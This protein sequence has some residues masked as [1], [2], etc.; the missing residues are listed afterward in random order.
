M[1]YLEHASEYPVIVLAHKLADYHLVDFES[2]TDYDVVKLCR[3]LLF[4]RSS[5]VDYFSR[6]DA[7]SLAAKE[8][9]NE[10]P[11][12]DGTLS[13]QF[14]RDGLRPR[15]QLVDEQ[16]VCS[17]DRVLNGDGKAPLVFVVVGDGEGVVVVGS[18]RACNCVTVLVEFEYFRRK[19]TG[20]D[21]AARVKREETAYG[22]SS[23]QFCRL[24]GGQTLLERDVPLG[25]VV[26]Q[27][28]K[29]FVVKLRL[30]LRVEVRRRRRMRR[31]IGIA[32]FLSIAGFL[33]IARFLSI[34]GFLSIECLCHV[35]AHNAGR[36]QRYAVAAHFRLGYYFSLNYSHVLYLT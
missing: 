17:V 15:A 8:A 4:G 36:C 24:L 33:S 18:E 5:R 35:T 22:C 30:L 10:V 1:V 2:T 28:V 7:P 6:C 3:P 31:V 13:Y 20:H 27:T 25:G 14:V 23:V 32:R 19:S 34:A 12:G 26:L 29:V 21:V 9:T 11:V 16:L